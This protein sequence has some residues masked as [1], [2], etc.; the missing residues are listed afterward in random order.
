VIA[1]GFLAVAIAIVLGCASPPSPAPVATPHDIAADAVSAFERSDWSPAAPLFRQLVVRDPDSVPWHYSLAV[2]ASHLDLRDEAVQEFEWVL[3]HARPSSSEFRVA[4]EWLAAAARTRPAS[5]VEMSEQE[6]R[7][8]HIGDSGLSGQVTG[9]G[10]DGA[11]P[12]ARLQ[13][14][15]DGIRHTETAG[16]QFVRRTDQDGRFEFKRIPSGPYIITSRV[17]G[18]TLWRLRVDVPPGQAIALDLT[19]ANSAKVRDDAPEL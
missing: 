7:A 6:R 8:N 19:P 13:L 11:A 16:L 12:R 5:T 17:P 10:N 15:L 4:R 2:C 9:S 3:A 1:R 14:F 18:E